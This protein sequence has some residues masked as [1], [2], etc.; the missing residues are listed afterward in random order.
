MAFS[1]MVEK[2]PREVVWKPKMPLKSHKAWLH[3]GAAAVGATP[4]TIVLQ[5]SVGAKGSVHSPCPGLFLALAC[6]LLLSSSGVTVQWKRSLSW[7]PFHFLP[8]LCQQLPV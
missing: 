4:S 1:L 2:E 8:A 5:A 7:A 6:V 3:G